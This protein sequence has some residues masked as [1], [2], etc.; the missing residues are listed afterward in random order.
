LRVLT[1][2]LL[3]SLAADDPRAIRSRRD[4]V[5][6]NAVMR[7]QAIMA[8]ALS[9]CPP[10]RSI[11][12]L[13]GGDGRFMLGVARR[14][15]KRWPGVKVLI[16]DQQ[17]IVTSETRT[18]FEALGWQCEARRGDV[19]EVLPAA[20]II[21]ANLFLHHF[22]DAS[23]SRLLEAVTAHTPCFVTCEPRRNGFA[24]L[25]SYLV[26]VLGCN[27]VT[28]H[29]AVASV[30]AGFTGQ[31]LSRLWPQKGWRLAERAGFPFTHVFTAQRD[32]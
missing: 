15:A 3:D 23:L 22:D 25:A 8:R 19:F 32:V 2:E 31:E 5:R 21:T 1:P 27:A 17:D 18:G 13:G 14:M 28:R 29:D 26:G 30:E 20:D 10:P 16:V 7:Q 4:L 12:D 11:A 9:A 24:L 6:I